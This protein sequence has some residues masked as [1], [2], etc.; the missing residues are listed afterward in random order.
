MLRENEVCVMKLTLIIVITALIGAIALPV[1]GFAEKDEKRDEYPSTAHLVFVNLRDGKVY[2]ATE[3]YFDRANMRCRIDHYD[4]E[5]QPLDLGRN[6]FEDMRAWKAFKEKCSPKC[7][8]VYGATDTYEICWNYEAVVDLDTFNSL[9]KEAKP[10]PP[11]EAKVRWVCVLSSLPHVPV[12]KV[13]YWETFFAEKSL[14][15]KMPAGLP[16]K[17]MPDEKTREYTYNDGLYV[18]SFSGRV[19]RPTSVAPDYVLE[20]VWYEPKYLLPIRRLQFGVR[21]DDSRY[22]DSVSLAEYDV[23][24]SQDIFDPEHICSSREGFSTLKQDLRKFHQKPDN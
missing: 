21:Q 7:V 9:S 16:D 3:M 2:N 15:A 4:L 6:Q 5:K 17:P 14:D 20:K 12:T 22:L 19:S 24:L 1:A 11:S 18:E 13:D 8:D 23:A 10:I